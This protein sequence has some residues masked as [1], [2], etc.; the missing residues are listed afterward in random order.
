MSK[1]KASFGKKVA[2]RSAR[3]A[4]KVT[5]GVLREGRKIVLGTIKGF[6]NA[7]NPFR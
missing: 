6:I 2:R 5:K 4:K 1:P 7:L 3:E